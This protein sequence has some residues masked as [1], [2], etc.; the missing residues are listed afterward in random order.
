MPL[1][2]PIIPA[3]EYRPLLDA[4]GLP[5]HRKATGKK[6][7]VKHPTQE[8]IFHD[9]WRKSR[10]CQREEDERKPCNST[11]SCSYQN[12]RRKKRNEYNAPPCGWSGQRRTRQ[13]GR[14]RAAKSVCG[15]VREGTLPSRDIVYRLWM[16]RM[17]RREQAGIYAPRPSPWGARPHPPSG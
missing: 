13:R 14:C 17:G 9:E 1:T 16:G 15:P 3:R 2:P 12:R 4:T 5:K 8:K 10:R 11:S 7:Q 6:E